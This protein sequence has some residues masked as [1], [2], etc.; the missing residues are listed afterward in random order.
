MSGHGLLHPQ[1][2]LG[3][4][5]ASQP[6]SSF[7]G[8]ASANL[9]TREHPTSDLAFFSLK[10]AKSPKGSPSVLLL[11]VYQ[12]GASGGAGFWG[13]VS[14]EPLGPA[15]KAF[16]GG[17]PLSPLLVL[18]GK[19]RLGRKAIAEEIVLPWDAWG[20]TDCCS[21]SNRQGKRKRIGKLPQESKQLCSSHGSCEPEEPWD[22]GPAFPQD[23]GTRT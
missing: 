19:K 4:S 17:D 2:V 11:P 23:R 6:S 8:E 18:S 14:L 22:P 3:E 7:G 20:N 10:T 15:G 21:T 16:M 9:L 1:W 5:I 12:A 13:R